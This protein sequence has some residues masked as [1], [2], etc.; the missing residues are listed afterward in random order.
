MPPPATYVAYRAAELI[1][2]ALPCAALRPVERGLA[3]VAPHLMPG[4]AAQVAR[5]LS[6]VYGPGLPSS[7]VHRATAETFASYVHYW[8]ESFRLPGMSVQEID[9]GFVL[10]GVEHLDAALSE[11]RGAILALPHLGGWEWA[12]FWLT[13][14]HGVGVT[15]VVEP[16]QP[17]ELAAWFVELR[18]TLGMEIVPLG[19]EAGRASL[20]ALRENRVLC[21]LC[22]RDLGGDGIAVPFL[23]ETTTLPAGPAVLAM[24]SGAPLLPAAVYF[25]GRDHRARIEAPL[26]TSRS[27]GLRADARRV[28]EDL[29]HA[30][31]ELIKAAPEQWHLMQ[32][33]WPSDLT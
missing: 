12:A 32:P 33:N 30:L 28:T 23:G 19:P 1:A 15:A 13:A 27:A 5:N 7:V 24:R 20:R 11:G 17:P 10:E 2:R 25:H 14:V 3:R 18:T 4:R 29:A 6:R 8:M 22:D 31:G 9:D 21:L 26:D 16:V